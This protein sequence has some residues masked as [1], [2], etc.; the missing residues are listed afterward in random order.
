MLH[1]KL[2]NKEIFLEHYASKMF[3][4]WVKLK[5]QTLKLCR[6]VYFD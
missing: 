5:G 2:R 3:D 4:P 6:L 1:F